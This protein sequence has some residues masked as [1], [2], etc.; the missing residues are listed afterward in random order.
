MRIAR[1]SLLAVGILVARVPGAG[2]DEPT[3]KRWYGWQMLAA[4]ATDA[5]IVGAVV[6]WTP[7]ERLENQAALAGGI[8]CLLIGPTVHWWHDRPGRAGWSLLLRVGLPAL[9]A[10]PLAGIPTG[11]GALA[12]ASLGAGVAVL[13]DDL[14]LGWERVPR[15]ETSWIP[16][17]TP[18]AGGGLGFGVART[19]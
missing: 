2:A 11:Q 18:V 13:I 10:L 9:A 6:L 15:R 1:I 7:D 8:A 4:D 12:G 16:T 14:A 17:V 19:W 3:E 5:A